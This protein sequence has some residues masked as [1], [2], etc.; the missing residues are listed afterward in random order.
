VKSG[1]READLIDGGYGNAPCQAPKSSKG[2][3]PRL[4]RILTDQTVLTIN[5]PVFKRH[6]DSGYTGALKNVYGMFDIP[7]EYH[8]PG[9]LT[10]MPEI[11][12]LPAIRNSI[13]LTIVDALN[14][15]ITGD[16]S[17]LSPDDSLGRI[18]LGQDPV[19]LD[20]YGWDLLNQRR[21]LLTPPPPADDATVPNAWLEHAQKI[22][23]GTRSYAL[24]KV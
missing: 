22:G 5:C 23:L 8:K 1:E 18:L 17:S 3:Y 10:A 4:S 24:V 20:S 15:V 7:G 12:A 21:A 2:N 11:Y 13:S 14:G 9:L 16:T 19:A 6:T